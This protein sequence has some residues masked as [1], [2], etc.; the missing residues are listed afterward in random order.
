M[1]YLRSPTVRY[2]AL[3]GMG[4]A[5]GCGCGMGDVEVVTP[6]ELAAQVNRFGP[7]APA[8]YRFAPTAFVGTDPVSQA[9][10]LTAVLIMQRRATD[11]FSQFHDAGSEAAI[12]EANMALND[13]I[14]YVTTHL[15]QVTK[16]IEAYADSLGLPG[17]SLASTI[18]GMSP[19]ALAAV[20]GAGLLLLRRKKGAR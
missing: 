13:P 8:A 9:L 7:S 5:M 6:A 19:L 14:A 20:A 10:A 4:G 1:T 15:G 18:A 16:T 3:S 12:A 2:P 11:A 17:Q